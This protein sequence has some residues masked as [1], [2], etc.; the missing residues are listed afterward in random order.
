MTARPASGDC[1][2]YDRNDEAEDNELVLRSLTTDYEADPYG[3]GIS[4]KAAWQ[5]TY[6]RYS[7]HSRY[8]HPCFRRKQSNILKYSNIVSLVIEMVT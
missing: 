1:C 8:G 7:F 6:F 3:P 4:K 5:L 2:Y